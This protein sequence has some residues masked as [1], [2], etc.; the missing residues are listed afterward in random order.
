M[1]DPRHALAK[2]RLGSWLQIM[3]FEQGKGRRQ[4]AAGDKAAAE[5][6]SGAV[7]AQG[8][9]QR[10]RHFRAAIGLRGETQ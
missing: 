7:Y 3:L 8:V 5:R 6:N 10:A 4:R 2:Y 9:V 1:L